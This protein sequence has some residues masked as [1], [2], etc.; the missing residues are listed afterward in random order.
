MLIS[1][2]MNV[3]VTSKKAILDIWNNVDIRNYINNNINNSFWIAAYGD[4]SLVK[5][6]IS[7]IKLL[8]SKNV[9]VEFKNLYPGNE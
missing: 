9:I 5:I 1:D 8:I 2:I 3:I 7:A 4:I 6:Q